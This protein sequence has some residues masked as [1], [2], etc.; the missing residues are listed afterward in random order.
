MLPRQEQHNATPLGGCKAS[1]ASGHRWLEEFREA[2]DIHDYLR[3]LERHLDAYLVLRRLKE[4]IQAVKNETS[5]NDDKTS[6]KKT[7][8]A[9]ASEKQRILNML[10]NDPECA[11][12]AFRRFM[13][14]QVYRD[15]ERP[16]CVERLDQ[17]G[18]QTEELISKFRVDR[19]LSMSHKAPSKEPS[20]NG[21]TEGL[22]VEEK[23]PGSDSNKPT[24]LS[25]VLS[26]ITHPLLAAEEPLPW[27]EVV[28]DG[29]DLKISIRHYKDNPEKLSFRLEGVV[30][31]PLISILSVLN[32]VDLFSSWVPYYTTPFKLGLRK[33]T[34]ERCGRVDQMV[35]F[36]IDF[37][38]PFANR[39]ACFEVFAVD[40]FERNS[41]IVVKMLTLDSQFKTPRQRVDIPE[42]A[43]KV[44]RI[45]VD[46][47]LVI[48][49]LSHQ[50]SLLSLVWHENCRMRVPFAMADFAT[51]LFARSAFQAFRRTCEAAAGGKLKQRREEN[52]FLY[53]F[54][55]SRLAEVGLD[56]E[57]DMQQDTEG[58]GEFFDAEEMQACEM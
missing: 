51:K 7:H 55:Q 8:A 13:V 50:C 3:F 27:K 12:T 33:V 38:W 21:Q 17:P 1:A 56:V 29:S 40:D 49:P 52:P 42:P 2:K 4:K 31:A 44:E 25:R 15:L 6:D 26:Q 28:D 46:G 9:E 19:Q 58:A 45:I 16:E 32:E 11:E 39:D 24:L 43:K 23:E 47:S 57:L 35:H 36:H 18:A 5:S 37:P 22:I 30:A 34:N 20:L 48:K 14:A 53:D 10:E 54:V 41:Q